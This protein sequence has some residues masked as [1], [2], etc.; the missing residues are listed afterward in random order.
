[1]TTKLKPN[2]RLIDFVRQLH[3]M[4]SS[5]YSLD[6]ILYSSEIDRCQR[7]LDAVLPP[8]AREEIEIPDER[9][10]WT[11][12]SFE[13][14]QQAIKKEAAAD[15]DLNDESA[16]SWIEKLCDYYQGY[17]YVEDAL[18]IAKIVACSDLQDENTA[19]HLLNSVGYTLGMLLD[20]KLSPELHTRAKQ[21]R[22]IALPGIDDEVKVAA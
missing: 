4:N 12:V 13:E 10:G 14:V 1:M 16:V 6:F 3:D 21:I 17:D 9:P 20:W 15:K 19:E 22:S 7:W 5:P 8:P 18:T 2:Y 11:R